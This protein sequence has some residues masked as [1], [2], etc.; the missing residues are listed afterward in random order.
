MVFNDNENGNMNGSYPGQNGINTFDETT[1]GNNYQNNAGQYSN[2]NV[3]IQQDAYTGQYVNETPTQVNGQFNNSN[4]Q[5]NNNQN[6]LNYPQVWNEFCIIGFVLSIT[7]GCC[8]GMIGSVI[9]LIICII[10]L[11]QAKARNQKG[12][13]LA[14]IGIGI[15]VILF[16]VGCVTIVIG[17]MAALSESASSY[18]YY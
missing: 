6:G 16:L 11:K 17:I 9:S 13:I 18:T 1:L 7:V 14:I 8:C 12:G 4:P 2:Q 15:S 3:G 10:G 5:Y